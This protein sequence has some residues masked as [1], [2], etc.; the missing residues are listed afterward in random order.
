MNV[1]ND[2]GMSKTILKDRGNVEEK[3]YIC[4]Q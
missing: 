2:G 4:R 3:A 1:E